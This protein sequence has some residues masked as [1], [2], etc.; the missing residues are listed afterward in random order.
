MHCKFLFFWFTT[1]FLFALAAV[2]FLI[3]YLINRIVILMHILEHWWGFLRTT[4]ASFIAIK[5][6][7]NICFFKFDYRQFLEVNGSLVITPCTD[8]EM[9]C[10]PWEIN[11]ICIITR[12]LNRFSSLKFDSFI[13]LIFFWA[14][15]NSSEISCCLTKSPC[16][17]K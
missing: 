4:I 8:V 1:I 7:S 13:K 11:C 14:F 5:A 15:S 3:F 17:S 9:F 6:V 16:R 2:F 12:N 10:E